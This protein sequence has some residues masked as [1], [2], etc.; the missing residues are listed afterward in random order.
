MRHYGKERGLF[1]S[2]RPL[3]LQYTAQGGPTEQAR[4]FLVQLMN[5]SSLLSPASAPHLLSSII[6]LEVTERSLLAFCSSQ[7]PFIHIHLIHQVEGSKRRLRDAA[8][9]EEWSPSIAALHQ[10]VRLFAS[11]SFSRYSELLMSKNTL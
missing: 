7:V 10:D 11:P 4:P 2:L 8:K 9:G 3:L 6:Y 5:S 1:I